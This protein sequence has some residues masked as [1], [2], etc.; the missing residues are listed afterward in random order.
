MLQSAGAS[1]VLERQH[2]VT[3]VACMRAD[4]YSRLYHTNLCTKWPPQQATH[5]RASAKPHHRSPLKCLGVRPYS[6]ITAGSHECP[7]DFLR[8]YGCSQLKVGYSPLIYF[9][10]HME[11]T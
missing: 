11:G 3:L 2:T 7:L 1:S 10:A 4:G 8:L 5:K 9:A 6:P